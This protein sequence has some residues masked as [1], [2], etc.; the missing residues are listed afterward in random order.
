[1]TFVLGKRK[2]VEP[3]TDEEKKEILALA[4][5]ISAEDQMM[6]WIR[7][8]ESCL[9]DLYALK[10]RLQSKD[11]KE[12]QLAGNQIFIDQDQWFPQRLRI[13]WLCGSFHMIM[14]SD[15]DRLKFRISPSLGKCAIKCC[16]TLEVANCGISF[17]LETACGRGLQTNFTAHTFEV[18]HLYKRNTADIP[19]CC[20]HSEQFV[21]LV[22][23]W[24]GEHP[25]IDSLVVKKEKHMRRLS[26]PFLL[27]FYVTLGILPLANMIMKYDS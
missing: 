27:A 4:N 7:K 5:R 26:A 18:K 23:K 9:L 21:R 8:A 12:N 6:E 2:Y 10:T 11:L 16:E 22:D 25:P 1:M 13:T 3:E 24:R 15:D 17:I 19:L 20:S 14:C